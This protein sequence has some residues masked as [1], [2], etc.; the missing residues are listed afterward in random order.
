ME[1]GAMRRYNSRKTF[2]WKIMLGNVFFLIN[3]N[4]L[5]AQHRGPN[6]EKLFSSKTLSL[7]VEAVWLWESALPGQDGAGRTCMT[8]LKHWGWWFRSIRVPEARKWHFCRGHWRGIGEEG[9]GEEQANSCTS[10]WGCSEVTSEPLTMG[11]LYSSTPLFL[12][13]IKPQQ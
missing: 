4:S 2:N 10:P 6:L 5:P 7:H 12:C 13:W 3:R 8:A 9:T 1:N 11:F